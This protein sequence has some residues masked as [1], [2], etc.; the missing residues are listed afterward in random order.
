VAPRASSFARF[1]TQPRLGVW[2]ALIAALLAT[3]ALFLGFYLDDWI[4]RYIFSDLEG[5]AEAL[6]VYRGG[7]AA[8]N[9]NPIDNHWQIEQG[10]APWWTYP[11]LLLATMR[12]ISWLTHLL[13][14]RLWPNTPWPQH[15]HS[16]L[17]LIALVLAVTRLYRGFLGPLIGGFAALL[18]A[19]DHTHG[20]EVGFSSNR[21]A[22]I[23]AV[24]GVLTL[25]AYRRA[26]QDQSR[27]AAM[28]APLLFVVTLL[29]GESGVAVLGYLLGHALFVE[30]QPLRRRALALAPYLAIL[31][32]WRL[33]YNWLGFGAHGSGPYIDPGREPL[34]YLTA[35]FERGPILFLGQLFL[36]PAEFYGEFRPEAA[37][38]H[39]QFAVLFGLAFALALVPL[40][41]RDKLAR[42]WATGFGLA[43][44]PAASTDAHNRQL[45]FASLGALALLAQLGHLYAVELRGVR[46]A[47][48]TKLARAMAGG[49]LGLHL[50]LSPLLLPVSTCSITETAWLHDAL[51]GL[52]DEIAGRDL[53]LVTAPDYFAVRVGQL[54][55]RI[56]QRPLPRHWRAL[57]F[58]SQRVVVQRVN[59]R[60]L[61]LDYE[62]G[63]LNTPQLELYR[64][65][66]LRMRAGDRI[67]LEGLSIEVRAVT[68]DGRAKL[69][70]FVFDQ[71]LEAPQFLFYSWKDGGL[72]RFTPPAIGESQTL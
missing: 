2:L 21:H 66:R 69:V 70:D 30:E 28:L 62:G 34:R 63:I 56:E 43:L 3:P 50:F 47:V 37:R 40:L 61:R 54:R 16:V 17:W 68:S 39:W 53:I 1:L 44:I 36:P 48:P 8:A 23:T 15:A 19:I 57:A 24:F 46:L 42:F 25:D 55:R 18:F 10:Y 65:R 72:A 45:L 26:R 4:A 5:A 20:W 9:G 60:T 51:H 58:G 31:I 29:A 33:A 38:A 13:D 22:L 14:A 12:P 27:A 67:K 7:Y 11:K 49:V 41:K 59:E 64:D 6:R 52:G 32:S 71:R 35:L